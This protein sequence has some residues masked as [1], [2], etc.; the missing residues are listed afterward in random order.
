MY[1][2]IINERSRFIFLYVCN[3]VIITIIE[4]LFFI[5]KNFLFFYFDKLNIYLI[6]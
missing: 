4:F 5:Y 3:V 1:L 6:F 2:F